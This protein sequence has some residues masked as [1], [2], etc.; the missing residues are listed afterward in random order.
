VL[1]L[2]VLSD[3]RIVLLDPRNS[4]FNVYTSDGTLIEHWPRAGG[5]FTARAMYVDKA[6]HVYTRIPAGLIQPGSPMPP[7]GLL[8]LS[9][10]GEV[11]DT[12]LAPSFPGEPTGMGGLMSPAK[13][14]DLHPDGYPIVGVSDRYVIELRKPE[15]TVRIEKAAER[16]A[17]SAEE[18]AE[19]ESLAAQMATRYGTRAPAMS[20]LP[21]IKP[22][23]RAIYAGDDGTIWVRL[24]REA[25]RRDP[26]PGSGTG[27]NAP[28]Q[29]LWVEPTVF[30]VF[31][32]DGTYLGEVRVPLGTTLHTYSRGRL[33][34]TREGEQ[35]EILVTRLRLVEPSR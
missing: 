30:D 21:D 3:G 5:L 6:D 25:V 15:G 22:F 18:K 28:P 32:A 13:I 10:K 27:P 2:S 33:W 26:P 7:I 12:I 34:A 20:G 35:G 24:Y 4:R 29:R 23:F 9:P 19:H 1:G 31:E 16:I 8:H 14:W 17:V 11:L